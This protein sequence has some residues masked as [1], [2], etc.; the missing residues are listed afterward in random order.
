MNDEVAGVAN[1]ADPREPAYGKEPTIARV[2][3]QIHSMVKER[4]EMLPVHQR[5]RALNCLSINPSST[6]WQRSAMS[7]ELHVLSRSY[8]QRDESLSLF[9]DCLS[10]FFLSPDP[11]FAMETIV[12]QL[13]KQIQVLTDDLPVASTAGVRCRSIKKTLVEK[14]SA[15]NRLSFLLYSVELDVRYC[16]FL[17]CC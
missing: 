3:A 16:F 9:W 13:I 12:C 8:Q 10:S 4:L 7:L 11:Y 5:A 2:L 6:I 17:V 1:A 14:L 15:V